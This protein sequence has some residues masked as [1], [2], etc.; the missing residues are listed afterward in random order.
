MAYPNL[1]HKLSW[2]PIAV[3]SALSALWT[4]CQWQKLIP[5]YLLIGHTALIPVFFT[6]MPRFRAPIEPLLMVFAAYVIIW[7]GRAC[8]GSLTAKKA[9]S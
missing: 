2:Y 1:I 8:T 3:L 6:S 9:P 7:I 5:L 4:V